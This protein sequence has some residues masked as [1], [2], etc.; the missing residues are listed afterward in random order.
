M[1]AFL[2]RLAGAPPFLPPDDDPTFSDVPAD[3]PFFLEVEWLASTGVGGGFPDGTF[4]PGGDVTRQ[5][6]A[7]FLF[8]L[9]GEP[10]FTPPAVATFPD[11]PTS[12]PFFMEIE[13]LAVTGVTT[14]FDD[15]TF[16]PAS[17]VTRQAMAAF[18]HRYQLLPT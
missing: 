10:A 8:R 14:G 9:A 7:A 11:T 12:H 1:A 16:R 5:A 15:G 13:W 17:N 4:R 6:M 18:L 2:S 3:H